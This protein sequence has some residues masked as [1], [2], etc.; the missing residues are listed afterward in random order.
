MNDGGGG[1]L[2]V[3]LPAEGT[4][5]HLDD[6]LVQDAHYPTTEMQRRSEL[7]RL[8][9]NLQQREFTGRLGGRGGATTSTASALV[10]TSRG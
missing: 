6:R 8:S 2:D 9:L 5:T 4:W 1:A 7:R 3:V 10:S